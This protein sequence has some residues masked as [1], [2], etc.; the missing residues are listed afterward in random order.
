MSGLR[1]FL[2][3]QQG[4]YSAECKEFTKKLQD[5]MVALL[6]GTRRATPCMGFGPS[7]ALMRSQFGDQVQSAA[8]DIGFNIVY[9]DKRDEYRV[10]LSPEAERNISDMAQ[11]RY[12]REREE[13]RR[14]VEVPAENEFLRWKGLPNFASMMN[15]PISVSGDARDVFVSKVKRELGQNIKVWVEG[16]ILRVSS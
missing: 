3:S 11:K 9:K 16:N 6:T 7:N 12:K 10:F 2:E 8:R 13:R 1:A 5:T 14:T 4:D 15:F